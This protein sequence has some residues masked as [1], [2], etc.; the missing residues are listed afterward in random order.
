MRLVAFS[1]K[2]L[3]LIDVL[4]ATVRADGVSPSLDEASYMTQNGQSFVL[5]VCQNK[6]ILSVSL[7]SN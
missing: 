3:C 6:L 4:T 7:L 1:E 5:G 2:P